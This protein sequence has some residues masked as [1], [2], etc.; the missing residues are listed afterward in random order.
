MTERAEATIA[1]L[2][3]VACDRCGMRH[4]VFIDGRVAGVCELDRDE[5]TRLDEYRKQQRRAQLDQ[6]SVE[7]R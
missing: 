2:H 6:L 7:A 1:P 4:V 5:L 3:G